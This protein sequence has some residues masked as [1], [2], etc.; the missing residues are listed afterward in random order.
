MSLINSLPDIDT[1]PSAVY[2]MHEKFERFIPLHSHTK[3][4][5]SYVEGGL[6]YLRIKSKTF[7]I[8]ARHYFWVPPGLEHILRVGN[9]ATVLRSIFF[10]AGNEKDSFYEEVGIYP[11]HDL[12]LQMIKYSERYQ[13]PIIPG[14]KGYRFL[15]TI[16][17]ILP[18]I[19]VKTLDIALPSTDNERMSKVLQYM[20][21]NISEAH[22][23]QSISD[24]F[25]FSDRSL[26]RLFQSSLSISFLQ[27]L[28]LLRMVKA[29]EMM[30]KTDKTLGEISYAV[31]YQSLSAFSSTFRQYTS[32]SPSDF[33]KNSNLK[34]NY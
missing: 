5:L 29:L 22:S 27:Y 3:G 30:L 9:S 25:G 17:E 34:S 20:D 15:A 33:L 26:S 13:G 1:Q 10:Y 32:F 12:L 21:K 6:A 4:Q 8:P 31:G 14:E 19:S 24:K 2:V 23:L 7:V 18:E 28:K 16:K 11:I